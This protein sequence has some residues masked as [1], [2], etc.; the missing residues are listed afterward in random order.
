[1]SG[2]DGFRSWY[3]KAL[4]LEHDQAI[5]WTPHTVDYVTFKQTL[6]AYAERRS[7]LRKLLRESSDHR[8]PEELITNIVQTTTII[9]TTGATVTPNNGN[10]DDTTMMSMP[11]PHI[12]LDITT[13]YV[14][15]DDDDDD[16]ESD[17]G[18]S[19][20]STSST[21][22][23]KRKNKRSIMRRVSSVE[24]KEMWHF[25]SMELDKAHAYYMSQWQVLS[26]RLERKQQPHHHDDYGMELQ[27]D[28]GDAILELLAFCVVNVVTIRQ[29]LIRYD[30]FART[31]EG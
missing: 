23:G 9:N 16:L 31:F 1:M 3:D 20:S 14:P 25:L 28:I 17:A 11:D 12:P 30:A 6:K 24:R 19:H 27:K 22:R 10:H 5:D 4:R 21:F 7:R 15:F 18:D 2:I 8:L 13:T 29:I 26:E